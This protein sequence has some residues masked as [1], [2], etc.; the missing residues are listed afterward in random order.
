MLSCS[1][2]VHVSCRRDGFQEL[3]VSLC[4]VSRPI[5]T[6]MVIIVVTDLYDNSCLG[7]LLVCPAGL[8]LV[9][10]LYLLAWE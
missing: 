6:D 3:S 9:L 2:C 7:P 10:D 1:W 5:D 4:N 8:V